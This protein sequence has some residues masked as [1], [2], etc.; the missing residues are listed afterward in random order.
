MD[1]RLSIGIKVID[2]TVTVTCSSGEAML[3][4]DWLIRECVRLY[5]QNLPLSTR[6]RAYLQL[7]ARLIGLYHKR[8]GLRTSLSHGSVFDEIM[9]LPSL[10]LKTFVLLIN[11]PIA[12]LSNPVLELIG[13]FLNDS[14]VSLAALRATCGRWRRVM[15]MDNF[16]QK[17]KVSSIF[18][19]MPQQDDAEDFRDCAGLP[20]FNAIRV[21]WCARHSS[22]LRLYLGYLPQDVPYS[23]KIM[24][25]FSSILGLRALSPRRNLILVFGIGGEPLSE[26]IHRAIGHLLPATDASADS[27]CVI[28]GDR[29]VAL[30]RFIPDEGTSRRSGSGDARGVVRVERRSYSSTATTLR[31]IGDS[32]LKFVH[33]RGPDST[34]CLGSINQGISSS[35]SGSG[36][37][38]IGSER[39][40][41]LRSRTQACIV[42][43]PLDAARFRP[44]ALI[45]CFRELYDHAIPPLHLNSQPSEDLELPLDLTRCSGGIDAAFVAPLLILLP[46]NDEFGSIGPV[47]T[48]VAEQTAAVLGVVSG[49]ISAGREFYVQPFNPA[50]KSK[51]DVHR[52]GLL[53]GV[54]W[55]VGRLCS[56]VSL[57]KRN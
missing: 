3:S 54:N 43:L 56:K 50:L 13:D 1:D 26:D 27:P 21:K 12:L 40:Q 44:A 22:R 9:H 45:K 38:D 41:L 51:H 2:T 16:W 29:L 28:K 37:G 23:R 39:I 10:Q 25:M 19:G 34:K 30:D 32:R 48:L 53:Y 46:I 57:L 36:S 17:H 15:T 49:L 47:D 18:D 24:S 5:N 11:G 4:W 6:R 20:L 8:L 31:V 55:L 52:H 14:A 35:S 42:V 7:D 33:V